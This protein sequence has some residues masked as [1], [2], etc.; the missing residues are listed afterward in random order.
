MERRLQLDKLLEKEVS[1][2]ECRGG[3]CTGMVSSIEDVDYTSYLW[4]GV[5]IGGRAIFVPTNFGSPVTEVER[6]E[7]A[8]RRELQ[9]MLALWYGRRYTQ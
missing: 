1:M 4:S 6:L 8:S 5:I 9:A 7:E 3:S 2:A